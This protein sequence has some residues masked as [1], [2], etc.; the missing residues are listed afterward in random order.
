MIDYDDY[1]AAED[2]RPAGAP[3]R[4]SFLHAWWFEISVGAIVVVTFLMLGALWP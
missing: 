2:F 3:R 4:E 1:R